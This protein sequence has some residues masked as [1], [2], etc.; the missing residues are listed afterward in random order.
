[1]AFRDASTALFAST[2]LLF[3]LGFHAPVVVW[4][5]RPHSLSSSQ[6]SKPR[7]IS[8]V[9]GFIKTAE[10]LAEN[11]SRFVSNLAAIILEMDIFH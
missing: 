1:M 3:D 4:M 2:I 9:F 5:A 6:N 7:D 10:R 8:L 11:A